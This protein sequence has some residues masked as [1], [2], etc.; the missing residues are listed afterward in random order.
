MNS[1]N[2]WRTFKNSKKFVGTRKKVELKEGEFFMPKASETMKD[3]M[4]IMQNYSA[5]ASANGT[6]VISNAIRTVSRFS[7]IHDAINNFIADTTG[8]SAH[9]DVTERL[10]ATSGI[11]L[12]ADNDFS[13][14]TG[15]VTGSNAGG[16]T[17]KNAVSIVPE[18]STLDN[19]S[20]PEE[21]S[22]TTHTYTGEDGKTFTFYIQWP[23]SFTKFLDLRSIASS[24]V[25][26]SL[27]EDE[28]EALYV[29]ASNISTYTNYDGEFAITV[30]GDQLLS[31]LNVLT[32]G[33]YNFWIQEGLKLAYDSYGLDFDGKTIKLLFMG[34]GFAA[35]ALAMTGP[36]VDTYVPL[37]EVQMYVNLPIYSVIDSS[38]PN[39]N[40]RIDGGQYQH[41]FDRTIAHELI[42]AV[43]QG[44]GI[45][46]D[47]TPEFFSEGVAE[48]VHGLDDYDANRRGSIY[49]LANSY[50]ELSAAMLLEKGTGTSE[51]YTSGYM[52]LRYLCQQS[53]ENY[54][55]VGNDSTPMDF[56]YDGGTSI[57]SKYKSDDVIHCSTNFTGFH[58]SDDDLILSASNGQLYLRSIRDQLVNIADSSGNITA[59]A[60]LDDEGGVVDYSDYDSFEMIAGANDNSNIISVGDGGSAIWGGNGY[61]DDTLIGGD[62]ADTFYYTGGN[63]SDAVQN[64]EANDA[65]SLFN[66]TMAQIV[67][68]EITDSGVNLAF[69]D[70]GSLTVSGQA[71]KFNLNEQTYYADYQN[72]TWSV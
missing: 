19:L 46:K 28:L 22:I 37:D 68:A 60:Y 59:L 9:S 49:G 34:G 13:V 52:F 50:E 67:G 8:T 15:A 32:K 1:R 35:G 66:M 55:Q 26:E 4:V 45:L 27:S 3:F 33:L 61:A 21:G 48:L 69:S 38:D 64:A 72:K 58:V 42:H 30:T 25:M 39:G 36:K 5:D 41:Y 23:E 47:N 29:D 6:E 71:G 11:V 44:K 56:N 62:G 7:G 18:T 14:D 63:G 20:L 2:F 31:G 43:M 65:V 70:G 24:E 53:L 16:S 12:G 40:T 51:R 57:I 10:K 17:V 54:V